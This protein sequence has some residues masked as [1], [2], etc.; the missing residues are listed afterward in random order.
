[1]VLSRYCLIAGEQVLIGVFDYDGFRGVQLE[2]GGG[3]LLDEQRLDYIQIF[4][5]LLYSLLHYAAFIF[6][7]FFVVRAHKVELVGDVGCLLRALVVVVE[8]QSALRSCIAI[9]CLSSI[10]LPMA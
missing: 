4:A 10:A 5:R 6:D 1:M 3:V 2:A 9:V 8:R 7:I